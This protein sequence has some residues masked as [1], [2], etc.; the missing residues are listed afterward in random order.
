MRAEDYLSMSNTQGSGMI[1]NLISAARQNLSL[2]E[3]GGDKLLRVLYLENVLKDLQEV[4][5]RIKTGSA[6][7]V[8]RELDLTAALSTIYPYP[9]TRYVSNYI[10]LFESIGDEKYLDYAIQAS[11]I[12]LQLAE[13]EESET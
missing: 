3:T 9:P 8:A 10:D 5:C 1:A 13:H 7:I 6:H 12:L 4:R 2:Y 11:Q